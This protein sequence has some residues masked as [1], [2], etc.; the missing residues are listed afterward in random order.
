MAFEDRRNRV[1]EPFIPNSSII[2]SLPNGGKILQGRVIIAGT[3]VVS[4]VTTQG[5]AIGEGGPINLIKRIKIIANRAGGSRYVGGYIVDCAPR[6]LLRYAIAQHGG[7]FIGELNGS[8][9]GNGANGTYGIYLSIPIFFAD[10]TLR[11]QVSTALNADPLD[12]QGNPIY[13]SIQVQIDTNGADLTTMFSGNNGTLNTSGLTVQWQD[14]RLGITGDTVPLVQDDH[15]LLIAATQTRALDAGWP[16]DGAV[17]QM[18]VLAEQGTYRTLADTLL[19]RITIQSPT[20]N[21]DEYALDIRQ[22][23]YDDEWWDPAQTGVGQ[24]FIDFTEGI[25]QNSN[26]AAGMAIQWDVN[27]VSGANLDQL[28]VY[29][30]RVWALG[31]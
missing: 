12:S 11:N 13:S 20:L 30:R 6:S 1:Q 15:D 17:T 19:N 28:K 26:G 3:V 18:L 4:G 16:Q 2:F 10:S 31:S 27:N 14:E 21:F 22:K 24:F 7:K 8:T 29:T 23:M 5:T 9:L 25:L